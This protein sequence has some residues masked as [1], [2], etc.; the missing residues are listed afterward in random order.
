MAEPR[1]SVAEGSLLRWTQLIYA[2]HAFSL[3]TGIIGAATVIGAF[4]T[5]WP[6]IIAVDP[7]LREAAA[8]FEAPGSSRTS[9]GRFGRSGSACCGCRCAWGSW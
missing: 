3:L 2:L 8:T 6:S 4:L 5:G 9:A 1:L 7:Q